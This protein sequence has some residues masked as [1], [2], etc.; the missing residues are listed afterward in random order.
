MLA[1]VLV[2]ASLPSLWAQGNVL[3]AVT[4]PKTNGARGGVL[5]ARVAVQLRSGFHVNS[6]TPA[7]EYLIPLRL[8]WQAAPLEVVDVRFPRPVLENYAFSAKPV[9]VFTGDFEIVSRFKVPTAAPLG[10]GAV[11]GKLRYQACNNLMCLAPKNITVSLPIDIR[12]K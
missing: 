7:D 2:L 10:P 12:A 11:T 6:N 8:T 3:T 5:T 4:P 9:S 1:V